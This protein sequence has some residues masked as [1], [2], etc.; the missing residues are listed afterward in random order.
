MPGTRER[1]SRQAAKKE[2]NKW[3]VD[4]FTVGAELAFA[5]HSTVGTACLALDDLTTAPF[6]S[7]EFPGLYTAN[8]E[9]RAD[10]S[11]NAIGFTGACSYEHF[12]KSPSGT[13]NVR[14]RMVDALSEDPGTGN[15]ACTLVAYL[16]LTKLKLG[17]CSRFSIVQGS[18]MGKRSRIGVE[19][20]NGEQR[21]VTSVSMSSKA[22]KIV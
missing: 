16:A 13:I 17:E 4:Y 8:G 9:V 14:V 5:G 3:E 7:G 22:V 1:Y 20:T 10:T 15:S 21:S 18:E 11:Y 6:R 19:V 12:A 2:A